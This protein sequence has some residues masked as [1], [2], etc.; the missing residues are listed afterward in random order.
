[1]GNFYSAG[2]DPAF[3]SH[4]ANVD[5]MWTIWKTL[6]GKRKDINT[7]DSLNTEFFFYDEKKN[8]YLVKVRDCLDNKKMGYDFQ[9]MPIDYNHYQ[10]SLL[11]R[12]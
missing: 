11:I 2:K 6:G 4:H 12:C 9:A 1:M 3:Y 5:R 8:P 7:P 10:K